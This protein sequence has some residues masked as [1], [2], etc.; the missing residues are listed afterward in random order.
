LEA[1]GKATNHFLRRLH[2]LAL[3]LGW[4]PWAI[5]PKKL[6]PKDKPA[7]KIAIT[8]EEYQQIIAAETKEERKQYYQMLWETGAS[9]TDTVKLRAENVNWQDRVLNYQ[10]QKTVSGLFHWTEP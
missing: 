3:D 6:W 9:Q 4:L 2:N 10:R 5:L 7:S 8:W 1:G